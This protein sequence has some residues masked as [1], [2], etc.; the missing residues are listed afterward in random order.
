MIGA[1]ITVSAACAGSSAAALI[2]SEII[3]SKRFIKSPSSGHGRN[4]NQSRRCP[5]HRRLWPMGRSR[6]YW[7]CGALVRNAHA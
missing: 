2:S 7:H 5:L 4:G 1:T 3:A 6:E